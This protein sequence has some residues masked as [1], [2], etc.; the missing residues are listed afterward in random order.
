MT[1]TEPPHSPL[2]SLSIVIPAYNEAERLPA[3]LTEITA[4]MRSHKV[5]G[6]IIVVDDGSSDE[7]AAL[8]DQFAA[9]HDNVQVVSLTQNKGKGAAVRRGVQMAQYEWVLFS[10]A[11]LSTP[12]EEAQRLAE[13]ASNGVEVVIGSRDVADSRIERH[14]PWYREA[15]GRTFN[16]IVQLLAIEGFRDTQ[17]GFK[18]LSREAAQ[19]CFGHMTIERFAFDVEVLYLAQRFG[20]RIEEVGVRWVNDERTT[21]D[22]LRDA[23]K[24]FVDVLRIRRR[25]RNLDVNES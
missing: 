13:V 1:S 23:T 12:I 15:M 6:E 5:R 25:H 4:W 14:Q 16:R 9:D 24:M 19:R 18:L 10:D 8:A 20:Y 21:V 2:R 11:D 3:S 7:T 22:P 17:C